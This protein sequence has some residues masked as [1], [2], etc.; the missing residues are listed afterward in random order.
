[1]DGWMNGWA[2]NGKCGQWAM[3]GGW[4]LHVHVE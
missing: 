2:A 1:M 4:M 3:G